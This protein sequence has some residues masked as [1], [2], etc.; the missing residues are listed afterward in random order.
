M[1]L[2]WRISPLEHTV[3]CV[4]EG[5]VTAKDIIAY[6]AA[7]AAA[8]AQSYRKIFDATRGECGLSDAELAEMAAHVRSA[9]SRGTPAPVAVV[10]GASGNDQVVA[11]LKAM[12]PPGQRRL[13]VFPNIHEARRWVNKVPAGRPPPGDKRPG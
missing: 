2:H 13:R 5:V 10:T 11:H 7:I 3:V 1:P 6:F 9:G 8:G 12:T 4:F